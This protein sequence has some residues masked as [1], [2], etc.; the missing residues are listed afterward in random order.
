MS[1]R[2]RHPDLHQED[3]DV[4]GWKILLALLATLV[5]AAVFVAAAAS[6]VAANNAELRPSGL[7]PERYL[8]PRRPVARVRQ[9]L[10]NQRPTGITLDALKRGELGSYG[11]VDREHGVARIP[12]DRAMDLVVEGRL[13]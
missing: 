12:I 7:F 9:D 3:D 4:P 6:M 10:F 13:P 2:F 1:Y 8:G 5:V 11:W